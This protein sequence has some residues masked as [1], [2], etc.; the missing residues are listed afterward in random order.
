MTPEDRKAEMIRYDWER[1]F[2]GSEDPVKDC[3]EKF[4]LTPMEAIR[5]YARNTG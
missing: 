5:F 3:I 4:G 1:E 2:A